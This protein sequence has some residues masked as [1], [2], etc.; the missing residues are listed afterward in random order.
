M[1][2]YEQLPILRRNTNLRKWQTFDVIERSTNCT[3]S[4]EGKMTNLVLIE[5]VRVNH[6]DYIGAIVVW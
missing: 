1:N 5:S 6:T 4:K 3:K 2:R